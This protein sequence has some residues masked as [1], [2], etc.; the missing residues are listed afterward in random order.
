MKKIFFALL[1]FCVPKIMFCQKITEDNYK[2][3][4][5][6]IWTNY[7][8][9]SAKVFELM[10]NYP[11]KKDSLKAVL[12]QLFE[13][14]NR[15]NVDTAIKYVS[16]PSGLERL[17]MVR[18]NLDKDTL[19]SIFQTLPKEVQESDYGKS[20][21]LHI[22]TEQIDE[23]SKYLDFKLS[24]SYGKEYKLSSLDGKVILLLYNGLDCMGN[25]GREILKQIYNKTNRGNFEI[26]IYWSC[27]TLEE[28]QKIRSDFSVD[29]IFVSDFQVDHSPFK[30]T[31]GCQAKPTCFLI[32]KKGVV[33]L[34]TVGL[35]EEKLIEL[36]ENNRFE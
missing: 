5:A 21:L 32:D 30:I 16:V 31:Y 36:L 7:E 4:D 18:L 11:D 9:E 13:L 19:F 25:S 22:N 33:Y 26:V 34:K 1:L 8:N 27:R 14:A 29:Y 2:K 10:Q 20:I 3:A 6:T 24:D 17:Y 28:L 35:P 15:Q 23:G 12:N